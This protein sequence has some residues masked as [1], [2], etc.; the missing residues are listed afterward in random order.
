VPV[1]QKQQ[2]KVVKYDARHSG[3]LEG[4]VFAVTKTG[5]YPSSALYW[6]S[7]HTIFIVSIGERGISFR[8]VSVD[9][10]DKSHQFYS[11]HNADEARV[12]NARPLI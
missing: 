9:K 12:F 11:V 4:F 6:E 8:L 2:R 5:N 1:G 7:F 3:L 10:L